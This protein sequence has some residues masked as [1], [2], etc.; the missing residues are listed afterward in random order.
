MFKKISTYTI[1]DSLLVTFFLLRF[2]KHHEHQIFKSPFYGVFL[3]ILT[4]VLS[5]CFFEAINH[6]VR[7]RW[8]KNILGVFF[9]TIHCAMYLYFYRTHVNAEFAMIAENANES[10]NSNA[11]DVVLALYLKRDIR[12][13]IITFAIAILVSFRKYDFLL[14]NKK[15]IAPVFLYILIL[16]ATPFSFHQLSFFNKSIFTYFL[17]S[18]FN[19]AK[20]YHDV[21]MNRASLSKFKAKKPHIFLIVLESFPSSYTFKKTE[22]GQEV[23]PYINS[24]KDKSFFVTKHVSNSI[25]TAKSMYPLLC[26]QIP[27]IRGKAFYIGNSKTQKCLPSI[28]AEIGYSTSYYSAYHDLHFDNTNEFY[29][30]IKF[31][32]LFKPTDEILKEK[33]LSEYKWGW[34]IEDRVAYQLMFEEFDRLE[35]N[36]QPQF[37]TMKTTMH[38]REFVIP[39]HLKKLYPKSNE[40]KHNF[41]NSLHL[42]DSQLKFFFQEIEKRDLLDKSL[43][44]ITGDHGYPNGKNGCF[45][46]ECGY[47]NDFFEVP[48]LILSKDLSYRV[49]HRVSSHIDV[50]PTVLDL[51]G[52]DF[53]M[54]SMGQSIFNK[55]D[56]T[57]YLIQPYKGGYIGLIKGKYKYLYSKRLSKEILFDLDQDPEEN[58]PIEDIE[59]MKKFRPYLSNIYLNNRDNTKSN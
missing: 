18:D 56:S 55:S 52:S 33:G 15:R 10:M 23:T 47:T 5:I 46:N 4:Y 37:F 32:N 6:L 42:S 36:G 20:E 13:I 21:K 31:Q 59:L 17:D 27:L 9:V 49:S 41:L 2:L 58:H 14:K 38:H 16:L 45:G 7:N 29:Q 19:M 54:R 12:T 28:L 57:A 11:L 34:G 26:S 25:Q 48:F 53:Q 40:R 1:F 50:V 24:L 43:I 3:T 8:I 39:D 30:K 22:T 51:I 35:K 44:I